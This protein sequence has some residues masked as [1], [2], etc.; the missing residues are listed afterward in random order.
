MRTLRRRLIKQLRK[1]IKRLNRDIAK[2]ATGRI[3]SIPEAGMGKALLETL[4]KLDDRQLRQHL[5]VIREFKDLYINVRLESEIAYARAQKPELV[6]RLMDDVGGRESILGKKVIAGLFGLRDLRDDKRAVPVVEAYFVHRKC[7]IPQK[8]LELTAKYLR[9]LYDIGQDDRTVDLMT[10]G[11][12]A[13]KI[14]EEAWPLP[15]VYLHLREAGKKPR[16][17]LNIIRESGRLTAG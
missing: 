3:E 1:D 4:E 14:G 11:C 13:K 12:Y 15:V 8:A 17:A 2:D 9:E 6:N 5:G 10:G 7:T 16:E